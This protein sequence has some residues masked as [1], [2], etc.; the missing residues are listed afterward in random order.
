MTTWREYEIR[1]GALER[2]WQPKVQ[3][4]LNKAIVLYINEL[5]K[6]S[7]NVDTFFTFGTYY[8][9]LTNIYRD[10][11]VRMAKI[12]LR[13]LRA[14]MPKKRLNNVNSQT[15]AGVSTPGL[16]TKDAAADKFRDDVIRQLQLSGLSLAQNISNT[17]KALIVEI[18][19]E[20]Q[21]EGWGIERIVKEIRSRTQIDNRRRARTIARTEIG[22]AANVG[23][24]LAAKTLEVAMDKKWIGAKDARERASHWAMNDESV[25][26]DEPFSNGMMAPGDPSAPA[27]E[28]INCRCTLT[29]KVKRDPQGNTIPRS[30]YTPTT[31]Y[32]LGPQRVHPLRRIADAI[33]TGLTLGTV[34]REAIENGQTNITENI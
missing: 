21:R 34:I 27:K 4:T 3:A 12:Q 32:A 25:D 1:R 14:V 20:G 17:T 23:K 16:S 22:R 13:E 19:S 9:L 15:K 11:G 2:K 10:A 8:G 18:L 24:I 6:G 33:T 31:T 29:F 30:Y 5:K 7:A 26:M 28:T